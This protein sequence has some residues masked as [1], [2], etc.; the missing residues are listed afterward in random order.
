MSSSNGSTSKQRKKAEPKSVVWKF[1]ILK[2]DNCAYCTKCSTKYNMANTKNTTACL[3]HLRQNHPE[4]LSQVNTQIQSNQPQNLVQ[5][6]IVYQHKRYNFQLLLDVATLVVKDGFS[7]L[8]IAQSDFLQRQFQFLY[9]VSSLSPETIRNYLNIFTDHVKMRQKE[10]IGKMKTC[11]KRCQIIF[12]ETST[13]NPLKLIGIHCIFEP[14]RHLNLGI[15]QI[16]GNSNVNN[17]IR[18]IKSKLEFYGIDLNKDVATI[19]TDGCNTMNRIGHLLKPAFHQ[20]CLDNLIQLVINDVIYG[21]TQ[22]DSLNY[23]NVNTGMIQCIF[24]LLLFNLKLF[25]IDNTLNEQSMFSDDEQSI[26]GDSD[27]CD[28]LVGLLESDAENDGDSNSAKRQK[29]NECDME[30]EN[31]PIDTEY[32]QDFENLLNLLNQRTIVDEN[33]NED[34]KEQIELVRKTVKVFRKPNNARLLKE[35]TGIILKLDC[36]TSWSSMY[37]MVK[38]FLENFKEIQS[39]LLDIDEEGLMNTIEKKL[40]ED[41]IDALESFDIVRRDLISESCNFGEALDRLSW[42]EYDLKDKSSVSNI[43][44]KLYETLV[45]RREANRRESIHERIY[46]TLT[47]VNYNDF[48]LE[49]VFESIFKRY[50]FLKRDETNETNVNTMNEP[51]QL[52]EKEIAYRN[53]FKQKKARQETLN[54]SEILK[55]KIKEDIFRYKRSNIIGAELQ[56][57]LDSIVDI[58][59]TSLIVERLSSTQAFIQ[60]N[61]RDRLQAITLNNILILRTFFN[62]KTVFF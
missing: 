3:K 16:T 4:V 28:D 14:T 12:D 6:N 46:L 15:I 20:K 26:G 27:M 60:T 31:E 1:F 37:D 13:P 38:Q 48:D 62:L 47:D 53:F 34:F 57:V 33:L 10:Y 58:I 5:Q 49:Q 18:V 21:K 44:S 2:N 19:I 9:K 50:S 56:T 32:E 8:S 43:H 59:P 22:D 54:N 25:S 30:T 40:L 23:G 7:F 29:T 24:E 55:L 45:A 36:N 51:T 39:C 11:N 52:S 61:I 41:L 35:R 42:L 17:I